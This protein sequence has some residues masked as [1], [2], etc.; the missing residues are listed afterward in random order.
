MNRREALVEVLTVGFTGFTV[1]PRIFAE[2][3]ADALIAANPDPPPEQGWVTF[4]TYANVPIDI[5]FSEDEVG[6]DLMPRWERVRRWRPEDGDTRCQECHQTYA[7][8]FAP[9][10]IWNEVM[11]GPEGAT[12]DPGGYLCPRCFTLRADDHY[13]HRLIWS[14]TPS[15]HRDNDTPKET[16]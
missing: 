13:G 8:W 6:D 14:I 2:K 16:P 3:A 9:N 10:D 4:G 1:T 5:E 12:E 11:S 15:R 7:P